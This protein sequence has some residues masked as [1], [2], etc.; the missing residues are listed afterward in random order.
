MCSSA[1]FCVAAD[2]ILHRVRPLAEGE[3]GEIVSWCLALRESGSGGGALGQRERFRSP[4]H[5][6]VTH[7]FCNL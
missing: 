5:A 7:R 6:S 2:N 1:G 3:K 4:Y